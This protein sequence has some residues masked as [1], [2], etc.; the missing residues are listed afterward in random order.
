VTLDVETL[1]SVVDDLIDRFWF[2][3]APDSNVPSMRQRILNRRK[4][5]D[6]HNPPVFTGRLASMTPYQSD[7]PRQRWSELRAR[8][9][10]NHFV[11]RALPVRDTASQRNAANETEVGINAGLQLVEERNGYTFQNALS[12]AQVIDGVGILHWRKAAD[13]YPEYPEAQQIVDLPDDPDEKKR[14]SARRRGGR[15]HETPD[16]L[17]E[18]RGIECAK[19]GF[20]WIVECPD[21]LNC[22]WD[23]DDFG[24]S[25]FVLIK[26]F[27][28]LR[29]IRDIDGNALSPI[30]ASPAGERIYRSQAIV[31]EQTGIQSGDLATVC[32]VWTRTHWYEMFVPSQTGTVQKGAPW[33]LTKSAEHDHGEPPFAIVPATDLLHRSPEDRYL[34]SLEGAFRLKA[35]VDR[36][37][38]LM[39]GLQE[40]GAVGTYYLLRQGTGEPLLGE[41]GEPVALSGDAAS[42]VKVPDGYEL[43]ELRPDVSQ[44]YVQAVSFE[45]QE[46]TDAAPKTGRTD[47]SATTSPWTM[48]FALE[49]EN[50]EPRALIN[51]Q[52][53]AFQKMA[54]NMAHVISKE[55]EPTYIFARITK[56]NVDETRVIAIDPKMIGSLDIHADI[57]PV[58]QAERVSLIEHGKALHTDGYITLIEFLDQYMK[59]QNPDKIYANLKAFQY[60]EAEVL[61]LML[62]QKVASLVDPMIVLGPNGTFIGPGGA[63]L[64]PEQVLQQNGQQPIL[65]PQPPG[66]GGMN[67]PPPQIMGGVQGGGAMAPTVPDL[68]PLQPPGA[69]R[70]PGMTG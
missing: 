68:P 36:A 40:Q 55:V 23:F 20:P 1:G 63:E 16:S 7:L 12:D 33:Q 21:V 14:Y 13:L 61:P 56:G 28:V 9:T 58:S 27:P 29:Y 65:P 5:F 24:L 31:P 35:S 43:K 34:P 66:P 38:S 4:A 70:M 67:P 49:M 45:R 50:A 17:R 41:D 60:F 52:L 64:P 59:V 18:R 39:L 11:V 57:D 44:G 42:A 19:A 3:S 8:L 2:T 10:E 6:N 15:Y 37:V 51:S 53:R 48:R 54:R 26:T 25:T 22:A 32:T 30:E 62:K 47:V 69:M 46:Y